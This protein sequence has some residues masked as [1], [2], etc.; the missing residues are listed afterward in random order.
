MW[1]SQVYGH[2]DKLARTKTHRTSQTRSIQRRNI[3]KPLPRERDDK[4]MTDFCR[5]A[6]NVVH[7]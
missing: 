7:N 3:H 4:G 5:A 2:H 1:T 6:E